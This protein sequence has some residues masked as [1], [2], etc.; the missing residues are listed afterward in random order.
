MS[1]VV[2]ITGLGGRG[3]KIAKHFL[4]KKG[5]IVIIGVHSEKSREFAEQA[6]KGVVGGRLYVRNID[7]CSFAGSDSFVHEVFRCTSRVDILVNSAGVVWPSGLTANGYDKRYGINFLG[8]AYMCYK[9]LPLLA[10]GEGLIVNFISKS[11]GF[12]STGLDYTFLRSDCI[13]NNF[14][15]AYLFSNCIKAN[16]MV[17]LITTC[18]TAKLARE[19]REKGIGL[20]CIVADC[21]LNTTR[22]NLLSWKEMLM[23]K[24]LFATLD[25]TQPVISQIEALCDSNPST[26]SDTH[27]VGARLASDSQA[28]APLFYRV[29]EL[30]Q[31]KW[32]KHD[33]N[34]KPLEAKVW[35]QSLKDLKVNES[36]LF[37]FM[38]DRTY[39]G[40]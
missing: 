2:V 22:K 28:N 12:I 11:D 21:T 9:L 20:R 26:N 39:F 24:V 3:L 32:G 17:G 18:F 37:D 25:N 36:R 35:D 6:L 33:D 19:C 40:R 13:G 29:T 15:R 34:W 23:A 27:A 16:A 8:C 1:Y 5:S 14:E 31:T 10:C 38:Q 7:F 30:Q 4:A